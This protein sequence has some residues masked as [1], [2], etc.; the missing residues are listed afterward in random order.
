MSGVPRV[1][2]PGF[3]FKDDAPDARNARVVDIIAELKE[4]GIIL[5]VHDSEAGV[6]EGMHAYGQELFLPSAFKNLDA[7]ILAVFRN[8]FRK[9]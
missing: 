4:Y 2:V 9:T 6:A 8:S 7:L 3:T 1:G 5:L